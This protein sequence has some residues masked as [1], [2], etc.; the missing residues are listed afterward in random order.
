M[1]A[2]VPGA[3]VDLG[4]GELVHD[5]VDDAVRDVRL[6]DA[7]ADDRGLFG[8]GGAQHV[9]ARAVAEIDAEAEA[10]GLPDALGA[11]VED[12]GVDVLGEQHLR[13][14]LPE[15]AE[16]DDEHVAAGALEILLQLLVALLLQEI[17][18]EH[19]ARTASA[20]S[21]P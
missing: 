11:G 6:V 4:A 21:S 18:A 14:D 20:P 17:A 16:A 2:A 1:C 3:H 19:H 15:A 10:R 9:A 12:G 8:A 7:D 13:Q 5:E